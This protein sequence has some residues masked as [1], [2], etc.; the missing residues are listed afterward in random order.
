M[1][2]TLCP[3]DWAESSL[4]RIP[5]CGG[6]GYLWWFTGGSLVWAGRAVCGRDRGGLG[7]GLAG[8]GLGGLPPAGAGLVQVR[9]QERQVGGR[10]AI[11]GGLGLVP[12]RVDQRR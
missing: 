5:G 3:I 9:G 1:E 8:G 4:H 11:A 2:G 7:L 10:E 6:M 12:V